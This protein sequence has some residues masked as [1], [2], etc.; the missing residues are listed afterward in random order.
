MAVKYLIDFKGKYGTRYSVYKVNVEGTGE[1]CSIEIADT[2]F[3]PHAK[4]IALFDSNTRHVMFGGGRGGGKTEAIVWGSIIKAYLVPKS[5]QI[6]LR[7]TMGELKD[8]IIGRF[9]ELPKAL[10]GTYVGE[11][12]NEHITLPN[13]SVIR[14]V[15]APTEGSERKFL[16]GEYLCA[17]FDEWSEWEY[18]VWSFVTGSVRTT[19]VYDILGRQ[20]VAQVIG[21]TNPGG[22]GGEDLNYLFGCDKE[23]QCP[24]G[25]EIEYD[26][27]DYQFIISMIDDNPAYKAGTANGDAYRKD[28]RTKPPR[29]RAAWLE[30]KWSGF[31]GQYFDC[32]DE[33]ATLV[34]HSWILQQ[35]KKQYWQPIW[36]GS[37]YGKVHWAFSCWNTF[38]EVETTEGLVKIPV[39]YKEYPVQG[40]SE[41]AFAAE[42]V[43]LTTIEERKRLTHL[44]ISP[45]LGTDRLSR[46]GRMG[47]LFVASEMPRPTP[48]YNKRVE[49]WTLMFGLLAKRY[50]LLDGQQMAGWLIS[51]DC[52]EVLSALL[53]AKSSTK[54]GE[55]GEIE[56]RK[57]SNKA[58]DT[59]DAL[60]YAMASHI[61][62]E[63]KPHS[64]K[65]KEALALIP[66][67]GSGRFMKHHQMLAEEKGST[68]PYYIGRQGRRGRR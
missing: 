46:G 65:M 51:K 63:D 62:P 15:S 66:P 3:E 11:Q 38:L 55:D 53:W 31:E 2:L 36:N 40:H 48:A 16:S 5:K 60:R 21:C 58:L 37:D 26:P 24:K 14:F 49:G 57:G 4:Q 23:K 56:D 13:G 19:T 32:L 29:L 50:T 1:D 8:T 18:A 35:M 52:T 45:E 41:V 44:Y 61:Q 68:A 20:V 9:K 54:P 10:V 17:W 7:R 42:I 6:I 27:T 25:Q 34:E 22:V 12:S 30:G 47:D 67:V 64:E 59:L 33:D 28:L 39:T 43:D